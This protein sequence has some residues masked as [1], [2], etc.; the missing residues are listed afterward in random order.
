MKKLR[1]LMVIAVFY[2][3]T[4]GAEKQAEKLAS[5]LINKNIDVTV[6][7]G[8]W[9]NLLK[10]REEL[11]GIKIMRNFANPV[12]LKKGKLNTDIS[13]FKPYAGKDSKLKPVKITFNKIFIRSCVYIYQFSLLFYLLSHRK[14]YDIVHVHQVL[15]P[16][17]IS[18]FAARMLKKP[19]IAKVG[20][21][22]LN[23]DINQ[24]KKLAEG[25]F[26]L[27]YILKNL[28]RLVCTSSKMKIEFLSEGM[29]KDKIILIRNGVRTEDFNR[30]YK[31]CTGLVYLGRFIKSK[32]IETLINAFSLVAGTNKDLRLIL[33]GDGPEKDNII[34]LIKK[35]GLKDNIIMTGMINDPGE[36]LRKSDMFVFPSLIEGLS[37]S[38]IEAMSFKLPCIVSNIPGNVEVIGDNGSNY[39]IGNGSFAESRYGILFNPADVDG[40][41][42]S[43]EYLLKSMEARERIG[44][45][46]YLKVKDEFDILKVADKYTGLYEEVLK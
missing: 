11:N 6:V 42:N 31:S 26:Q 27:R 38:L 19:V 44:E 18:T 41:V 39:I 7:T 10:R 8:R 43:I 17:F 40:L 23:S 16:A 5:E 46:A 33:I 1:I 28:D 22:G 12:F 30:S 3:Y 13:F 37:N 2:P 45:N 29:K 36:I 20:S 14:N 15:F 21:S 34:S 9:S 25:R 24:I 35:S 4:G 32:D